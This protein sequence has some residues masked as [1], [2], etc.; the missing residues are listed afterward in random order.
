MRT[1]ICSY[2]PIIGWR[3]VGSVISTSLKVSVV[4]IGGNK[5]ITVPSLAHVRAGQ[6]CNPAKLAVECV[7]SYYGK[8]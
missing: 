1:L 3:S 6:F 8:S 5:L 4:E 2:D 7:R